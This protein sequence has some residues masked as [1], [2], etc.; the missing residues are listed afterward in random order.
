MRRP[1]FAMV[2]HLF[3]L[4]VSLSFSVVNGF[5]CKSVTLSVVFSHSLFSDRTLFDSVVAIAFHF[6]YFCLS[7]LF[8]F[9]RFT[10]FDSSSS[11]SFGALRSFIVFGGGGGD[12]PIPEAL[13]EIAVFS[14][15]LIEILV[16]ILIL[17]SRRPIAIPVGS[18]S[19]A[20]S[21]LFL[22]LSAIEEVYKMVLLPYSNE[23]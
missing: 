18:L 12:P 5:S 3:A 21:S 16:I 11:V 20:L 22:F 10:S 17:F 6:Q 23:S 4:L 19:V 14:C 13:E 1:V 8:P 2:R 15:A 9:L 7:S